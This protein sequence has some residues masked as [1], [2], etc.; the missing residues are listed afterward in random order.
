MALNARI[1]SAAEEVRQ[2]EETSRTRAAAIDALRQRSEADRTAWE[3]SLASEQEKRQAGT[4][5][6]GGGGKR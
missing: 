2:L 3:A 5:S 6:W 4:A 1:A